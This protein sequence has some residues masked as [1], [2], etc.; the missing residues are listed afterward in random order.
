MAD[1]RKLPLR[2]VPAD[3]GGPV[4]IIGGAEDK[5]RDRVILARFAQLAGGS[6]ARIVVIST[7]SS[8]GEEATQLYRE[9]FTHMGA[10]TVDGLRPLTRDE[11]NE[12]AAVAAV[13]LATGI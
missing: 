9:L 13:D 12:P 11:A 6:G 4:M 3:R 7:A 10:G 8:L 5:L 2:S 1:S